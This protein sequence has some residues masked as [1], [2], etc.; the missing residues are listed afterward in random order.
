MISQ[1]GKN[2]TL[3]LPK[4]GRIFMGIAPGDRVSIQLCGDH[5]ELWRQASCCFLCGGTREL[6]Q[7]G[8]YAI[9]DACWRKA[10]REMHAAG[11][12]YGREKE[13]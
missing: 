6:I 8:R 12:N 9:C 1:I 7:E 5:L 4:K 3:Y 11:Y 2:G 13:P 10:R